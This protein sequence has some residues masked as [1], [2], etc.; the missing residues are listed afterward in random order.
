MVILRSAGAIAIL[1]LSL[2][3]TAAGQEPRYGTLDRLYVKLK[4]PVLPV[5]PK[6]TL[7]LMM[8]HSYPTSLCNIRIE[9]TA[10]GVTVECADPA[11]AEMLP[12]SV[13]E[14]PLRLS[15]AAEPPTSAVSTESE[16][17]ASDTVELTLTIRAD[18]VAK[19]ATLHFDIPV[20]EEAADRVAQDM[21]M[22][23]GEIEVHVNPRRDYMYAL[24]VG[25]TVLLVAALVWRRV[26]MERS[27]G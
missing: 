20:T 18:E 5:A 4:E 14:V 27:R 17:P 8:Y 16:P 22:P 11:V 9:G 12:T 19:P 25:V 13:I 24:Y 3:A 7:R 15:L 2:C 1:L 10:P 26:R 6:A 21:A 23:V